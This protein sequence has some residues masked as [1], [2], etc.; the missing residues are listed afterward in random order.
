MADY[1][2]A[3][4]LGS[5]D[6]RV[7]VL[8]YNNRGVA[9]GKAGHYDKAIADYEEAIGLLPG[10]SGP[11]FNRAR[12]EAMQGHTDQALKWLA[13]A[14]RRDEVIREYARTQSDF[15]SLRDDPRFIALVGPS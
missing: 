14:I 5:L 13:E 10:F 6:G 12:L 2:R 9:R 1:T 3:I 11:Y 15:A 7:S 8:A 4:D